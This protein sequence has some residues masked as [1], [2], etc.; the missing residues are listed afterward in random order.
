VTEKILNVLG[1][2]GDIQKAAESIPRREMLARFVEELERG[3][4][5]QSPASLSSSGNPIWTRTLALVPEG[6]SRGPKAVV[7]DNV[8]RAGTTRSYFSSGSLHSRH[9]ERCFGV[10]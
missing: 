7:F 8:V 6:A 1:L 9:G 4:R 2:F 5:V 10:Q 3:G